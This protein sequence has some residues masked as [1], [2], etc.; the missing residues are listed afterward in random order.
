[1][2]KLSFILL[3]FIIVFSLCACGGKQSAPQPTAVPTEAPAT[4][5][6]TEVPTEVPAEEPKADEPIRE[7]VSPAADEAKPGE[8]NIGAFMAEPMEGV[9]T[10]PTFGLKL[11]LPESVRDYPVAAAGMVMEHFA[12]AN[13]YLVQEKDPNDSLYSF[14]MIYAYPDKL[15]QDGMMEHIGFNGIAVSELGNNDALYYYG[16]R[17]DKALEAMPNAFDELYSNMTEDQREIHKKLVDASADILNGMEILDLT[18]PKV[19]Q[20]AELESSEIMDYVMPDLDGNDVRLGDL[21]K[22]NKVTMLNVWG[23]D[24]GPCM[25]EMPALAKL[26]QKYQDQGF[27]I[28]GLTSDLKDTSGGIDPSLMAEA[29]DIIADLKVDYPILAMTQ[30]NYDQ[31]KIAGTP[32]TY[33]V[34]SAGN[35]IG[36]PIMGSKT[37]GDWEKLIVDA[38][39]SVK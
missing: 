4:A 32:T 6:P 39:A 24:C 1:M 23:I 17:T 27:G 10:I 34:D 8:E 25:L 35:N 5:V 20:V 26:S 3:I 11:T 16:L 14:A 13:F 15:D 36:D 29:K 2:K 30:A 21:I 31:M 12:Y 7:E 28:I 37:D 33:F 22:D 19:P 38:L 9:I 18:L